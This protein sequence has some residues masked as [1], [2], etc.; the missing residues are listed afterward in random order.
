MI[1]RW[2]PREAVAG[3]QVLSGNVEVMDPL[4]PSLYTV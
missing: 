3:G 1:Q 4:S 2:L